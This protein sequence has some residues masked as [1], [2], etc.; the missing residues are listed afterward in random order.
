MYRS[1]VEIKEV[2]IVCPCC[3]SRLSVDVRTSK[4]LRWSSPPKE[5]EE[6]PERTTRDWGA[7]ADRVG[8]RMSSA[9]DSFDSGLERERKREGDLDDLFRKANDKLRRK[10]DDADE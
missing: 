4:V 5:G 8:Q 10:Q 2:Q 3:Q 7:A 9:K 6:K 1:A